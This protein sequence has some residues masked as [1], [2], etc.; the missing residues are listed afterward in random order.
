MVDQVVDRPSPSAVRS[1]SD[2]PIAYRV[3]FRLIQFLRSKPLGTFGVIVILTIIFMAIFAEQI[4]RYE[5]DFVFHGSGENPLYDPV[6]AEQALTNPIIRTQYPPETFRKT[7]E[8][9]ILSNEDP[10]TAHWLG[11]DGFGHDLYS[12]I[13][14]GSRVSLR[15]GI[16]ASLLAVVAGTVLG[17]VSAYFSGMVDIVIQRFVDALQ[18]FPALILL[19]LIIQVVSSPNLNFITLALGILG[20]APVVRIVRS[21][22]LSTREEV[23]VLAANSIGASNSR[24]MWR[25]ILPNIMAPIIV[26]FS[27]SISV[28]ILAEA[29]LSFLGFGDPTA[30]SWG[31]MVNEGRLLGAA[32]PL[33][34]LWTG[35]AITVAVLGFSLFGDALRD[36][37]DP[38]LR[39][40]GRGGF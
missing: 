40:R 15:V 11:T 36:A 12:R 1:F 4:D 13:I 20:I 35:L 8:D 2:R 33:M 34:A 22:V 18:A 6:I 9:A 3:S 31:K 7:N 27:T 39:G 5:P 32:K 16:G 19:L 23:Y 37:L 38:R 28:Y 14:H 29:G 17:V 25:H 24:I 26:I 21:A 30:I 10:S